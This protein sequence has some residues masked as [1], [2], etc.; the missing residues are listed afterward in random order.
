MVGL[1]L[2]RFNEFQASYL[3]F[4]DLQM[5]DY[6]DARNWVN[7]GATFL[8]KLVSQSHSEKQGSLSQLNSRSLYNSNRRAVAKKRAA[9]DEERAPESR[10]RLRGGRARRGRAEV[11]LAEISKSPKYVD[12]AV[13]K[14]NQDQSKMAISCLKRCF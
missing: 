10:L 14:E 3:Q 8:C 4:V 9:E 7:L 1:A 12:F 13:E 2:V 5:R 11:L 6:L